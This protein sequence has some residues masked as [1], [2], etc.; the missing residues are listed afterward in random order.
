MSKVISYAE[1]AKDYKA[2]CN[3]ISNGECKEWYKKGDKLVSDYARLYIKQNDIKYINSS[4]V[5][6]FIMCFRLEYV[7]SVEIPSAMMWSDYFL[8]EKLRKRL[9]R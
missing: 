3:E 5:A 6:D 4:I 7:D 1:V 8:K 2:I 9:A